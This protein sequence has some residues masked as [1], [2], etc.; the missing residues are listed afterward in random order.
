MV[1]GSL[2]TSFRVSFLVA[3]LLGANNPTLVT[4]EFGPLL[5]EVV[6]RFLQLLGEAGA[7]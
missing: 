3:V 4:M 1:F 5:L 2:L 6:H 7:E